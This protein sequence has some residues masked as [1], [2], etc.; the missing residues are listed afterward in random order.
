MAQVSVLGIDLA[1]QIFHVV[2]LD[3][4]G[5]PGIGNSMT[6]RLQNSRKSKFA[7]EPRKSPLS[8]HNLY[9][10]RV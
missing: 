4:V 2:G 6:Y 5:K 9:F 10:Q 3:D 7:T 1:K 8:S